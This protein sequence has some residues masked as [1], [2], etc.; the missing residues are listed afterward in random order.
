MSLTWM[1]VLLAVAL[2]VIGAM[3]WEVFAARWRQ[4]MGGPP[5]VRQP[6]PE[7]PGPPDAG[8]HPHAA[9]PRKREIHR[10]GRR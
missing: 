8:M 5:P 4:L 1:L 10:S 6:P 7:P 2:I 9:P 3:R